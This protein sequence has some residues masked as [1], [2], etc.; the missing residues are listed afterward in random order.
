MRTG[1]RAGYRWFIVAIFFLF[2]LLHQ[3]DKLLIG[4]LTTPIMEEFKIGEGA[5]GSVVTG[6]LLVATLA[7]PLWGYLADRFARARL[8][9]ATAFLWGSTTWLSALAPNFGAFLAARASTGIDDSSYP[10]MYS[11]VSDYFA[12]RTRGRVYGLLHIAMPLGY[13]AGM[14]LAFGLRE[15]IGW[16]GIFVVTG[17]LGLALA[18]LMFFGLREAPRGGSEPELAGLAAA[19]AA[20]FSWATARALFRKRSLLLLFV[21]GFFGVFPWNVIVYWFFRYLEAERRYSSEQVLVTMVVAVL[22]LSVGYFVGG[23][24]G[25]F[26]FRRTPRGRLLVATAGVVSGAVLMVVTLSVPIDQ[27]GV[28][29]AMLAV[30]A[31]FIP[32]GSANVLATVHDITLPEVRATAVAVQ[33]FIEEVGAALAPLLAGVI[34]EAWS[35]HAAILFLCV[36]AWLV[37]ALALSRAARLVPDDIATLRRQLRERAAQ[38]AAQSAP[39]A[40]GAAPG[41]IAAETGAAGEI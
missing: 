38:A 21:Q 6:A 33:N 28:F 41:L 15:Q 37:C 3:A 22:V 14:L 2:V 26:L 30:T 39:D 10:G 24:L 20:R 13:L 40:A 1:T 34:A 23:A 11:L 32:F 16:R 7:Y 4:P 5:M 8:L 25:D 18:V 35:L 27:P 12:P 36:S 9:A 19:A 29:L 17:A 31:L